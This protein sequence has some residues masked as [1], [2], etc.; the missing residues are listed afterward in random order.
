MPIWLHSPKML[1]FTSVEWLESCR[2]I[3]TKIFEWLGC[4]TPLEKPSTGFRNSLARPHSLHGVIEVEAPTGLLSLEL[5][6]KSTA[7]F[8]YVARRRRITRTCSPANAV[9][10]WRV[11]V[12]HFSGRSWEPLPGVPTTS[13]WTTYDPITVYHH[14]HHHHTTT[15]TI[16]TTTSSSSS[17]SFC[18]FIEMTHQITQW[19][20][21]RTERARLGESSYSSPE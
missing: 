3:L 1:R 2:R 7:R 9:S 18:S 13:R 10:V 4:V 15:T 17:S 11:I 14:H 8:G 20:V 5:I 21:W 6:V 19:T 16:T 12:V